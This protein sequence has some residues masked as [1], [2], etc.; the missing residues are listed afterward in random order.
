MVKTEACI[1]C[2]NILLNHDEGCPYGPL[3]LP[4]KPLV[5]PAVV[6]DIRAQIAGGRLISIPQGN[7]E[8]THSSGDEGNAA[9]HP[10]TPS[11]AALMEEGQPCSEPEAPSTPQKGEG[12][13]VGS[14]ARTHSSQQR[15]EAVRRGA[16]HAGHRA[17]RRCDLS[18]QCAPVLAA[19]AIV[20]VITAASMF[21]ASALP[22]HSHMAPLLKKYEGT[23]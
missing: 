12:P 8:A 20:L 2:V 21:S 14:A 19:T 3:V 4:H 16:A 9:Q 18:G 7:E 11:K 15:S 13:P 5:V 10:S 17:P 1:F 6:K 22:F 23:P